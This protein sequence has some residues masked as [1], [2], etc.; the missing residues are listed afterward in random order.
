M[1]VRAGQARLKSLAAQIT[2]GT[3]LKEPDR[4]FLTAALYKISSGEDAEAALG[5]KAQKGERKGQHAQDSK[6]R[7]DVVNGWLAIA[8]AHEKEG[9]L[10]LTLKDA[11]SLMKAEMSDL[12]SEG[13][14]RRYW[15]D[16]RGTQ[17]EIFK[18]KTD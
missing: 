8:I 18:I 17:G 9:G 6:V 13:A 16:V 10:G 1:S 7:R 15:N 4:N 5:V 3:A 2:E 12:P 11:V 14:L